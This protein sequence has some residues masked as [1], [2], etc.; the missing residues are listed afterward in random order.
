MLFT[1]FGVSGPLV[2]SLSGMI[3]RDPAGTRLSI[4]LKPALFGRT[5]DRAGFCAIFRRARGN[6]KNGPAPLLL[7]ARLLNIVLDLAEIPGTLAVRPN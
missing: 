2:L 5:A 3:A 4:D 7:P 6:S 1:H